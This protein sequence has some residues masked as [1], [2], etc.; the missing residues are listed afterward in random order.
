VGHDDADGDGDEWLRLNGAGE[1]PT[2]ST[3]D[4]ENF[5]EPRPE[6]PAA[7]LDEAEQAVRVLAGNNWGFRLHASYGETIDRFLAIFSRLAAE[8]MF[9]IGTRWF[10]E[11]AE[12]VSPRSIERIAAL[13][14]AISVQNRT[15]FQAQAFIG[16]YG[17]A[18]AQTSPPIRAMLDTGLTVA[19]GTD[20]TRA[21]SYN[22]WLSL[23]WLVTGKDI[24][25]RRLRTRSNLVD[26]ATALA[27]YTSAGAELSGEASVKGTISIGKYADFA[28]LS[29]DY[30]NVDDA[31]ISRIESVLTVVGGKI[32]WSSAEFEGLAVPLPAPAPAWS[33]VTEFGGFHNPAVGVG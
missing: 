4:F 2:L 30:F 5:C 20:A 3:V 16:R 31:D 27:M 32:V 15:M 14:G 7:A 29:A 8:G 22:P 1:T 6:L 33:P 17:P 12:T 11:H 10:F 21:A 24:S 13:G 23:S 28:V 26:R 9:P 25:G 18:V 19:A